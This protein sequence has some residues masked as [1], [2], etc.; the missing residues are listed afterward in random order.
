[1]RLRILCCWLILGSLVISGCED[2]PIALEIK[3]ENLAKNYNNDV[4]VAYTDLYLDIERYLP[5]FRPAATARALAYI[6]MAAYEAAI[7]GMPYFVSNALRQPG[8]TM[9]DLPEKDLKKYHWNLAVNAC[10]SRALDHFMLNKTTEQAALIKDLE[11]SFNNQLGP[12]VSQ[13]VFNNSQKWGRA[14]AE[15]VIAFAKSDLEAEAHILD[16]QPASYVPPSGE[17]KWQPENGVNALFPYWGKSRTFANHG[18]QLN[19]LPPPVYSIAPGSR[20]YRD[21]AEVNRVVTQREG[22]QYWMAEFWSD[23]IVGLSFSPPARLF[24]IAN[25]II[26]IENTD[27]ETTLHMYCKLGFAENDGAVACWKAKYEYNVERPYQF[28]KANI[29]PDFTPILGEAVGTPGLT[30]NFPGYPSGHSTFG[31]L[32]AAV[33]AHFFGDDYY[34]TDRCHEGRDEFKGTPRSYS[35]IR[36]FGEE[37]AY[38][39]IYLGVHPRFDCVEGLRLGRQIAGNVLA[40]ELRKD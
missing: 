2:D 8:L 30:P 13:E 31:G 39:R 32:G 14:V 37:N 24:A 40:Y 28:I 19:T 3:R 25:Q 10:M 26:A 20:Y 27:L 15:A 17:G 23:D 38:S 36:E 6:N 11:A 29:N 21:F 33:L 22:Q 35:T 1:M 16:P 7:P 12:N 9:P 5:G 34:F 4:V 18:D